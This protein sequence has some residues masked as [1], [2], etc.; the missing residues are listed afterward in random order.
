M[1]SGAHEHLE[2]SVGSRSEQREML[3]CDAVSKVVQ[4]I[5]EE[6]WIWDGPVKQGDW[7]VMSPHWSIVGCGLS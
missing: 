6:L 7:V 4:P 3:D 2:E 5:L 1:L